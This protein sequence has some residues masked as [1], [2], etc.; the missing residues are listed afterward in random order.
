M[1]YSDALDKLIEIR[2]QIMS[3]P[4]KDRMLK[5]YHK[6]YENKN[7]NFDQVTFEQEF[8][9]SQD[10]MVANYWKEIV[11]NNKK[12]Q[13][14]QSKRKLQFEQLIKQKIHKEALIRVRLQN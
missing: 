14:F 2:A 9:K 1:K 11:E 3:K 4:P 5:I 13:G 6:K 12:G 8:S 10:K 7:I